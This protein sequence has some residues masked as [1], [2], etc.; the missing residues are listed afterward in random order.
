MQFQYAY[1]QRLNE[2]T[3]ERGH[4]FPRARVGEDHMDPNS[5]TYRTRACRYHQAG[6]CRAG[7]ECPF[8]HSPEGKIKEI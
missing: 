4:G 8:M 3:H 1:P 7:S 5:Y 2:G 6:Y